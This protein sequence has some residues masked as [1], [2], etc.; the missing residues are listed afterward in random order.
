MLQDI[1]SQFIFVLC[2]FHSVILYSFIIIIIIIFFIMIFF[3]M[4]LSFI[5]RIVGVALLMGVCSMY[6][7]DVEC[8]KLHRELH[9]S[10]M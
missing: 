10:C 6:K 1:N 5:F 7:K 8:F 3:S 2:I 4:I 9:E